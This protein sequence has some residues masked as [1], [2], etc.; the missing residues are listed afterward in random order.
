MTV[1]KGLLSA[2]IS[3]ISCCVCKT[4]SDCVCTM[5]TCQFSWKIRTFILNSTFLFCSFVYLFAFSKTICVCLLVC[6]ARTVAVFKYFNWTFMIIVYFQIFSSVW[7]KR[8]ARSSALKDKAR[9]QLHCTQILQVLAK[10]F[11]TLLL[12]ILLVMCC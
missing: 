1:Y 7:Q 3:P 5:K 4:F 2:N 9:V 11:T 10:Q 6:L 8:S 12:A